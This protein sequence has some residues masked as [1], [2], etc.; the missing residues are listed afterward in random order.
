MKKEGR[1]NLGFLGSQE[2][3]RKITGKSIDIFSRTRSDCV[4]MRFRESEET[5]F[6][7]R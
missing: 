2:I 3:H 7:L 4:I 1:V 5:F 6:F